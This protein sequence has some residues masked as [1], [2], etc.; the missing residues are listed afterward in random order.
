VAESI[1]RK[2]V[3]SL[4]EV[5]NSIRK[6][7]QDRYQS[8]FWVKAEMNKLNHYSYSGHC[9]PELVEKSGGRVV[10]QMRASLWKEDYLRVNGNFLRTLHEPLK[11]GITILFS[12]N[13]QFDPVHGLSLRIVDIDPV[14]SLGELEREKL[15]TLSKLKTEGILARNKALTLEPVPKRIAIISVETS[16]GYSDFLNILRNNNWGYS[17]FTYLFPALLQGDRSV[18]SIIAQLKRVNK[19]KHHFDVV[20]IIRGGGG[21]VGLSSYNHYKLAREI[22][23]FP[24]PV[25][26]GIGHSTNETVAEMVAF[27]NAIT[28]TELADFLIQ[29]FHDFATPIQRAAEI[30]RSESV[31]LCLEEKKVFTNAVRYFRSVTDNLILDNRHNISREMAGVVRNSKHLIT[32]KRQQNIDMVRTLKRATYVQH[33]TWHTRLTSVEKLVGLMDPIHVLRRGYTITL[34]NGKAIQTASSLSNGDEVVTLMKDGEIR[35]TITSIQKV[36]PNE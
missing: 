25:L 22:A 30:I 5:T 31:G 4:L 15:E 21:D 18:D 23:M 11:D 16:K 24:I 34:L 33:N 19:V 14:F 8:F 26:T 9:Y 28:P 17:F 7:M 6:T 13:I 32:S 10:A 2:K 20:A 1:N 27:R 36:D 12:A 3:F 35:S 29:K